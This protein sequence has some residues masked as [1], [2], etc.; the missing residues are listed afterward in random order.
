M[1]ICTRITADDLRSF[2]SSKVID[3]KYLENYRAKKVYPALKKFIIGNGETLDGEALQQEVF[4]TSNYHYDVF[5]SH[6]HNDLDLATKFAAYLEKQC[7]LSVFLDSYVWKSAD[8]LLLRLDDKYCKDKDGK[9]YIYKRRNYSTSHVHAM[10]SMAILEM[11]DKTR[12]SI[13]VESENSLKLYNLKSTTK[14]M[15]LSPWIYEEICMMKYIRPKH[16]IAD[17]IEKG[18]SVN[19]SFEI[20]HTID[21]S[22]LIPITFPQLRALDCKK[23]KWL[24]FLF[25]LL[26]ETDS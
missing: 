19:E 10:L 22:K 4:P 23:D 6:S 7:G 17:S 1:D 5:I 26:L 15:T 21:I 2:L 3:T 8:G 13:F 18:F 12:C 25:E 11:I 24:E 9:H 16:R 14:A 20:A